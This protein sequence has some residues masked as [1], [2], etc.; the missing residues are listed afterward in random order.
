MAQVGER[1]MKPEEMEEMRR[2]RERLDWLSKHTEF[3]FRIYD[4]ATKQFLRENNADGI[5]LRN[6]IDAAMAKYPNP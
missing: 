4:S 2:D 5:V 6:V 3:R 1:T